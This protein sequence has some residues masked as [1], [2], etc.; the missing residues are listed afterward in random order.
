MNG[1]NFTFIGKG[2]IPSDT[3]YYRAYTATRELHEGD[4][5][6]DKL[7]SKE[8]VCVSSARAASIC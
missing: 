8:K 1:I 2:L 7:F 6:W 5:D 4:I 3:L